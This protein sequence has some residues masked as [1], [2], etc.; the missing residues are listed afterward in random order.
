M[1]AA[2]AVV[3]VAAAAAVVAAAVV[4]AGGPAC[5]EDLHGNSAAQA[6]DIALSAVTAGAI[7]P[8]ADVDYFTVT[9]PGQGL[10][11]VDTTRGSADPRNDLA[12]R[13]GPGVRSCE[14]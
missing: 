9:V 13:D 1:A 7:C 10:I 6:T 5:A 4:V 11:F 8:A 2:A 14:R 12:R 3:A